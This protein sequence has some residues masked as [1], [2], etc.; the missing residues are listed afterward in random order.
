[1]L[2]CTKVK[3]FNCSHILIPFKAFVGYDCGINVAILNT[4]LSEYLPKTPEVDIFAGPAK[5]GISHGNKK[6]WSLKLSGADTQRL[7]AAIQ[8]CSGKNVAKYIKIF[9]KMAES[10]TLNSCS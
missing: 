9:L 7:K 3:G 8:G 5:F 6:I 4:F 1:M 2:Y 10:F